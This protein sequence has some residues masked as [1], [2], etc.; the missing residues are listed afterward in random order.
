MVGLE[1]GKI[2][3]NV[4]ITLYRLYANTISKNKIF[5]KPL[6]DKMLMRI[7][8]A[9]GVYKITRGSLNPNQSTEC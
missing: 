6:W 8:G 9:N 4:V 2:R 5:L 3:E 7:S 1:G